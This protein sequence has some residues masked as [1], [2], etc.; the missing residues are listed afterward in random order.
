MAK[1]RRKSDREKAL[2]EFQKHSRYSRASK[3]G[4]CTCISCGRKVRVNRCDGGHYIGR[5]NRATELEPDNCWPQC[6][7]CNGMKQG[8]AFAYRIN[9]LKRIG[10]KRLKELEN[11]GL[12]GQGNDDVFEDLSEESREKLSHK[13]TASYYQEIYLHYRTINKQLEKEI[14]VT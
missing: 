1:K 5:T 7:Q 3:D 2:Q 6:K 4:W 11:M 10:P 14:K 9:L 13:H 8:N 12:V